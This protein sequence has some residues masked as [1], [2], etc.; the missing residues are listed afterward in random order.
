[1]FL[2]GQG[3]R[4]RGWNGNG[5]ERNKTKK[6]YLSLFNYTLNKQYVTKHSISWF[7]QVSFYNLG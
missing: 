7:P 5:K 4:E 1:M 2:H 6:E 3:P